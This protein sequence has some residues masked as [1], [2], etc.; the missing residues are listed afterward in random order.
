MRIK[1]KKI[2]L[3][4]ATADDKYRSYQMCMLSE[5]TKSHSGPPD[6]PENPIVTYDEF[7]ADH[8]DCY[9][10]GSQPQNGRMF[11]IAKDNKT[12]GFI[13]YSSFHVKQGASEIDIWIASESNC[14][15]G[16]GT[17]AILTLA[18]YLKCELGMKE[19]IIR[20]SAK[21]ARAVRSYMR[22]GFAPTDKSAA[23]FL[24]PDY[25]PL[26]GD[27]DYGEGGDLLLV[28]HLPS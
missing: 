22:C 6:Y 11:A 4:G 24:R 3:V 8:Y 25:L 19:L 10:D 14:G 26:Y 5:T 13:T 12:I 17:D 15:K 23:D 1:G 16:F 18:D 21:N 2:E 9:F 7:M 20:P 27:G 28:K